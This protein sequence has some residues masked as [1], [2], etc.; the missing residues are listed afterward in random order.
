MLEYHIYVQ[1]TSYNILLSPSSP[2]HIRLIK[3]LNYDVRRQ[4][5]F[6]LD[7]SLSTPIQQRA[8]AT[9]VVNV[10]EVNDH[11]PQ[12]QQQVYRVN[13][14]ED[15]LVGTPI[16]TVKAEDLDTIPKQLAYS[17]ISGSKGHFAINSVSGEIAVA[18]GLNWDLDKFYTM[19]VMASDGLNNAIARVEVTIIP[20]NKPGPQFTEAVYVQ[21]IKE[22]HP[23]IS[24]NNFVLNVD[25]VNGIAPFTYSI[26]EQSGRGYFTLSPNGDIRLIRGVNYELQKQHRFTITVQGKR[27]SGRATV[28]VN[29]E[30]INDV[31]P[32]FSSPNTI[33]T[34]DGN[35]PI[36]ALVHIV[37]ATDDDNLP[38]NYTI[39]AGNNEGYFKID[40]ISG[41]IRTTKTFPRSYSNT[42]FLTIAAED[43]VCQPI[44]HL[45][46]IIISTCPDPQEFHFK[47]PKYVFYLREDRALGFFGRVDLT[48]NRQANLFILTAGIN[49]FTLNNAGMF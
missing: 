5:I 35:P 24:P 40:R 30:N 22:N 7:A 32:S 48:S 42:F 29:I 4:Y 25:H 37:K 13:V 28:I 38:F 2:G 45:A 19:N 31:C 15:T 47:R 33:S 11:P 21:T 36:N 16:V 27:Q 34:Y 26:N 18:G 10:L 46:Q 39:Q 17:I 3:T 12:F 41:E 9:V 49:H 6:S 1:D 23:T 20:V 8:V 43:G 14:S 44:T